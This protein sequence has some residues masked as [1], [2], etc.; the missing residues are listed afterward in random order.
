MTPAPPD[1]SAPARPAPLPVLEETD[2]VA[3]FWQAH[4][5]GREVALSTSGTS[6][7]APRVIVRSTASWVDS[8]DA[9]AQ[10][11]QLAESSRFWIPGP[12]AA[13]MNLFAACL[14]T[15]VGARWS[16]EPDGCTHAQ[17]TPAQLL[18]LVEDGAP[19]RHALV[20]GDGLEPGLRRRAEAAGWRVD[21]Y[22]G[23]AELSLVAWGHDATDLRLFDH[24]DAE[25]RNG[26]LWVRSPWLSRVP[27][28]ERGYA[29]VHD[30]ARLEGD[31]VEVLGRPGNATTA[32]ATVQLAPIEAEL[33]D[34]ASAR[35]VVVAVPEARLGEVVCCVTTSHDL[36]AIRAWGRTHLIGARRPRRWLVRDVLPLTPTGKIDRAG[37][38][39]DILATDRHPHRESRRTGQDRREDQA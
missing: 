25:V 10:R 12:L 21:H 39:A 9:C 32:G 7:G 19:G 34:H 18:A 11:L 22:Y 24:V 1:T 8:F 13:T 33:Q 35:V 30:V 37:L 4:R 28:D 20:A 3:A 36:R 6:S 29:S 17:L 31:H 14:A 23:A 26:V 2:P 5:E 38:V 15:Y 16:S 27:T